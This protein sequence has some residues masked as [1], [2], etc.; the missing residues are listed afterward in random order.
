MNKSNKTL[1]VYLA[2]MLL[3]AILT[4]CLKGPGEE[5]DL[6]KSMGPWVSGPPSYETSECE[7]GYCLRGGHCGV[8]EGFFT[9]VCAGPKCDGNEHYNCPNG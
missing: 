6:E 8:G 7:N 3:P 9:G 5:C 2:L 4:S 1:V